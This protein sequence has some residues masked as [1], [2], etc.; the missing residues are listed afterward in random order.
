MRRRQVGLAILLALALAA[1]SKSKDT[2]E[3]VVTVW[4]D[5]A[6]P[7]EM[8][9]VRIRV[10]G[11][12]QTIDHPFRLSAD[13]RPGT[14]QIPIQLALVP[15]AD[16]DL[17]ISIAA[18]GSYQ[19]TDIVSQEAMLSFIPDQARELVLYLAR[20]CK[21]VSC[22]AYREYTCE[23]GACTRPVLVDTTTLPA[24]A[25]GQ[26]APAHDAGFPGTVAAGGSGGSVRGSGGAGG[27]GG[28]T[29]VVT[30]DQSVLYFGPVDLGSTSPP[31]TVAVT[32][33]K[34]PAPLSAIV[35]GE[36]F[37]ISAN[38]CAPT[39]PVGT[40]TIGVVF[41]PTKVGAATGKLS[42][43]SVDIALS[44]TGTEPGVFSLTPE[45]IPLGTMLLGT[46]APATVTIVPTGT[47]PSLSCLPSGAELKT[48]TSTCPATG[49]VS[50]SCT[51]TFTFK[52]QSVGDKVDTIVCSGGGKTAQTTVTAKV[53]TPSAL[54]ISPAKKDDFVAKVGQA[55]LWVFNVF[56]NGG[57][58]TGT[59]TAAITGAGF[60]ITSNEC[61]AQLGAAATCKIQ[62]T[63][64]PTT[65]SVFTGA[66][67]VTDAT[68]GSTPATAALTGTG[69]AV[70]LAMTPNPKDFGTVEVGKSA[71]AAFTMTN[72][73]SSA[74]DIIALVTS[75]AQFTV[76]NDL[77]SGHPLAALGSPQ[78]SCTFGVRFAPASAGLK[79]AIA[80]A[81]Q[82]S[83]GA[84]LA[85]TTLTGAGQAALKPAHLAITPPTLDFGT[86]G[87]GVPVGPKLFTIKND[88]ETATGALTATKTDSPSTVGGASQFVIAGNTCAATLAPN[89]ICQVAVTFAPTISRSAAAVIIV[90]DG[91]ATTSPPGTG[92]T[93]S[94]GTVVGIALA[95]PTIV[96]SCSTAEPASRVQFADTMVGQTSPAV[97]CTVTN[98]IPTGGDTPQETGALT[99]TASGDFAIA[100]N[101]CT[102]SLQPN[103]SCTLA[104]VFRPTA[105]GVRSGTLTV[106]S[107]NR[108]AA[109]VALSGTGL[110]PVDT[111]GLVS[112]AVVTGGSVPAYRPVTSGVPQHACIGETF[113][114]EAG[115]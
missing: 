9:A 64:A 52:A 11:E 37:A 108:A 82:T 88:G 69:I 44:G 109:D 28:T 58:P 3:L 102:T 21:N 87:V 78:A 48:T 40:C 60:S 71:T 114:C 51:Y 26:A 27:T 63:F 47:V 111:V 2:T 14:Y 18:I 49:P 50:T 93:T 13:Q 16:K 66:L 35:T 96:I 113:S 36:G 62:V 84:V 74:T 95:I 55:M 7:A 10:M 39:Q 112:P 43:G 86:T 81:T 70:N 20:S 30:V 101:N 67:T 45:V 25:P 72:S 104:L 61:P 89:A 4:S 59:V 68:P 107:S 8:D 75:D 24:Y 79:Q 33:T 34:A 65:A 22:A 32:V 41:A 15:A 91:V 103:L 110:L 31:K 94:P 29:G 1:C 57:S 99:V 115:K 83:D 77:C 42:V 97:V 98:A 5:L 80:N 56:N 100:T 76:V 17:S 12:E 106:T 73:G 46:S 54:S 19:D 85:T 6:V 53:V 105:A 38:T 23:N 92:G 90:T